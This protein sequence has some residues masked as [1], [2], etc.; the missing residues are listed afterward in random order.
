MS[1]NGDLIYECQRRD[2]GGSCSL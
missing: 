1:E 2:F